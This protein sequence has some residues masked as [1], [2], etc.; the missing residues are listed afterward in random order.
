M[1]RF[2]TSPL[3]VLLAV[4]WCFPAAAQEE[5][6]A[7]QIEAA[8]LRLGPHASSAVRVV[9]LSRGEVLYER[10]PDLS[11]S[12]ASNMKLFT[13]AAA[14]AQLGPDYRFRTTVTA[15]RKPDEKGVLAGDLVLVGGGDPVLETEH[16]DQLAAAV[17]ASG[18]RKVRG[19]LLVDD[20]RFDSVRLGMGWEWDDEPFYYSAQ[21]SALNV[22]RG[23]ITVRVAPG[24]SVDAPARITLD[25]MLPSELVRIESNATT[26]AEGTAATLVVTRARG[27]NEIRI[28][29]KVPLAGEG[30]G[31][32]GVR[33]VVTVEEPQLYAGLLFRALLSKHGVDVRGPVASGRAPEA[34][35]VV[36]SRES[37]PLAEVAALLNKPSDNLVAEMLLKELGFKLGGKGTAPAGA[38]AV[39]TWLREQGIDAAGVRM[40][41]G[42]G[43]SRHDLV[44][45]RAVS[46]LLIR[47][48]RANWKPSFVASLPVAGVD[49]TLRLRMRGGPAQGKLA[50]KTGTLAY[51][52]ALAGYVTTAAGERLAFSVLINNY[53]GALSAKRVEDLIGVALASA[54]EKVL[55]APM[56]PAAQ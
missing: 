32:E 56:P 13:A 17:R 47:A 11:L 34:G 22:N 55:R 10:N 9:S 6:L 30:A 29:G 28:S 33:R 39:A 15:G 52:S 19:R 26:G 43:L 46:E 18:L 12:P 38:A 25:P 54:T 21:I 35:V 40:N 3:L 37:P 8:L 45:A 31:T 53:A 20:S 48:D 5:P 27:K 4:G 44:T 49:G 42:S 7:T 14:L 41:D 24:E 51:V 36:G 16:L 2:R 50:A 1:G 23:V